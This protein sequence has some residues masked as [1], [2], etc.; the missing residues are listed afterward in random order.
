MNDAVPDPALDTLRELVLRA[1]VASRLRS[2]SESRLL[3]SILDAAVVLFRAEAASLALKSETSETLDFVLAAGARG[4]GVVGRSI[5]IG[6]GIAGYVCQTGQPIA[7]ASPADD[8]R[9]GRAI[10]EQT[11]YVPRSILAVPL[12]TPDRTVGVMEILDC[13]D[14]AF[15]AQDIEVASVFASQ[16]AIAID[17]ARIEREFPILVASVLASYELSLDAETLEAARAL[18]ERSSDD[19]WILVD[20]IAALAQASP[21]LQAFVRDLLPLVSRHLQE[22]KGP[23]FAR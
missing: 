6:E 3:Q 7:L 23:R 22:S 20:E 12:L 5:A 2:R 8:V 11:G 21:R 9:F 19:F 10:A 16:A 13:R 1:A 18:Q 14:G 15:T 17:T 4:A